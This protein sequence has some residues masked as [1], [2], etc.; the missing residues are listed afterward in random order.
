[1]AQH[2]VVEGHDRLDGSYSGRWP[3]PFPPEM[4]FGD[5][6]HPAQDN[7][8]NRDAGPLPSVYDPLIQWDKSELTIMTIA[9]SILLCYCI[10]Y[11]F[12]DT[13][14]HTLLIS[15]P[16]YISHLANWLYLLSLMR[17]SGLGSKHLI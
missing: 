8:M 2:V 11:I 15:A 9:F 3:P 1:M 17:T 14:S 16:Y 4:C 5:L 6:A 12:I 7:T 13:P 10:T